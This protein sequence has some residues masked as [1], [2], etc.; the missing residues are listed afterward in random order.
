MSSASSTCKQKTEWSCPCQLASRSVSLSASLVHCIQQNMPLLTKMHQALCLRCLGAPE[1]KKYTASG[2]KYT[3]KKNNKTRR[4]RR[5]WKHTSFAL[6]P[7]EVFLISFWNSSG[8]QSPETATVSGVSGERHR[9]RPR[10]I[11]FN[12]EY[13][14]LF[15][16][17]YWKT[18]ERWTWGDVRMGK[19]I[20]IKTWG[21]ERKRS[22]TIGSD[23]WSGNWGKNHQWG[24]S[25]QAR[26]PERKIIVPMR[27]RF[28][29]IVG[30]FRNSKVF[31]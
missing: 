1:W 8:I 16:G 29:G 21:K 18:I 10:T 31:K 23:D 4:Y 3:R 9:E 19:L 24:Y 28:N 25:F 27:S 11:A 2:E 7:R 14:S 22:L 26:G 13:C 5:D 6:W 30:L 17:R 12:S 15:R 20:A